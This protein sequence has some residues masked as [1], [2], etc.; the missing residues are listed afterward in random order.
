MQNELDTFNIEVTQLVSEQD[1][2]LA[3]LEQLLGNKDM[4]S[5]PKLENPATAKNISKGY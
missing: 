2:L 4:S 5:L 3:E 1:T